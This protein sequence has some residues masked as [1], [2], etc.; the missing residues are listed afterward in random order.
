[1]RTAI[2]DLETSGLNAN[3][4]ILLCAVIKE[5][6]PRFDQPPVVIR[7]DQFPAWK[8]HRSNTRPMVREVV[9]QL[10][11]YD[12]YVAHNGQRFDKPMLVSWAMKYNQP[13]LLRFA[14]FIDP[15]LLARR[16]MRLARNSLQEL[17]R[18]LDVPED[19]THIDFEHW[20]KASMDGN[21]KSLDYI[22]EHCVQDVKS[23]EMVYDKVKRL[24]KGI[25]EKGSGF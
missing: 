18:F 8:E 20:L 19:K 16:H 23:L 21:R 14:K 22:V 12:I 4:S 2:F 9:D 13:I 1:M 17:I 5:Y 11:G 7:A 10:S 6:S 3:T 24:V 15:V 25:D